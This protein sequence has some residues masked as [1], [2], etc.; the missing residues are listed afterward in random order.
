LKFIFFSGNILRIGGDDN[1]KPVMRVRVTEITPGIS[2]Q[3][4][5]E[6]PNFLP[7]RLRKE[8]GSTV[9]ATV[10]NL[11]QAAVAAARKY[12]TE[13]HFIAPKKVAAK[14]TTK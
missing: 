8:N 6:L 2:Y 13:L 9:Y 11:K 5:V 3:G 12:K 1:M 10:S 7:T 14:K 4:L